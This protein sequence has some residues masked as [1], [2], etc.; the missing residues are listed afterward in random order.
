M[1]RRCDEQVSERYEISIR[2][3]VYLLLRT[4][5]CAGP[6]HPLVSLLLRTTAIATTVSPYLHKTFHSP[7]S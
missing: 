1:C 5:V 4:L 7:H 3:L 2:Y 6:I